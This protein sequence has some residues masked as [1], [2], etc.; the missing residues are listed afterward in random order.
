MKN[1]KAYHDWLLDVIAIDS[2]PAENHNELTDS[3]I[4]MMWNIPFRPLMEL[5]ENR[6]SDV[7]NIRD[8]YGWDYVS[9]EPSV[10]EILVT[11]AINCEDE[12]MTND[13]YGNRTYIWFWS[14]YD[15]L[16]LDQVESLE[17]A[18]DIIFDFMD[19]S[20]DSQGHGSIFYTRYHNR[21]FRELDLW[22]QM[23]MWLTENYSDE[24]S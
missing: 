5:D 19:R 14:M 21:D 16:G 12:I 18:E 2:P 6:I 1:E 22:W 7:Y 9:K 15:N 4:E 13:E 23:Q 17:E 10:L 8:I 11:M 3:I 24:I 20:Y